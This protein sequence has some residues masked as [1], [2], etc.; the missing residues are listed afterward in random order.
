MKKEIQRFLTHLEIE[1]DASENT[2]RAYEQDIRELSD[3]LS[4]TGQFVLEDKDVDA[5]SIDRHAIQSFL[6]YLHSHRKSRTTIER[7]I[8][9]IRS[10]FK[11]L[12]SRKVIIVNPT[13]S[14]PLPKKQRKLPTYLTKNEA[15]QLLNLPE[16][17]IGLK[18]LRNFAIAELFY[19]T[20]IR[21]SEL[22]ALN[23]DD[24]DPDQME[25]QVLGKGR[26]ERIVPVTAPA[27]KRIKSYLEQRRQILK[28]GARLGTA[29][30][31]FINLRGKRITARSVHR[32]M[33]E[34]GLN[35]GLNKRVH[36]HELRH[37]FAT[38][39]LDSG[40]D[41]RAIQELL[42]HKNL[43]TTQKYTHIS[44]ERLKKI[45]NDKHPRAK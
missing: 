42:G 5:T 1:R 28:D 44:L 26:K 15:E 32:I 41:L 6:S 38:H 24:L 2:L 11:F 13:R 35:A 16:T 22:T 9:A 43:T 17:A 39:L 27:L 18:T 14:I 4:R 37:S 45:Y 20:G 40:A 29:G 30:P 3:F 33:K 36:P 7:K 31:L 19:A 10:F 34:M 25:L 21:V 8:A 23:L 12:K